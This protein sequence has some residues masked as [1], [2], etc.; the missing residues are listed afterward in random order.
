MP[1]DSLNRRDRLRLVE[2][3]RLTLHDPLEDELADPSYQG[4]GAGLRAVRRQ[5]GLTID[6]VAER[7]RIKKNFIQAIEAG[8]F[9]ALPGSSYAQGFVRSYAEA[10][11]LDSGQVLDAYRRELGAA[12]LDRPL[13]FPI[14]AADKRTPR[15]WILGLGIVAGVCIYLAWAVLQDRQYTASREVPPVPQSILS[16]APPVPEPPV[17]AQPPVLAPPRPAAAETAPSAAPPAPAVAAMSSPAPAA[18]P[19]VAVE[20]STPAPGVPQPPVSV[21]NP[22]MPPPPL[23]QAAANP[24][25]VRVAGVYGADGAD[26]RTVV[27]ATQRAWIRVR[28]SQGQTLFQRT[29][30]PSEVY[31]VPNQGDLVLDAGNLGGIEVTIDG[32]NLPV[33]GASSVARRNISLAPASLLERAGAAN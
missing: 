18:P 33:L 12:K 1:R 23:P 16:V 15:R 25:P 21:A 30:E 3:S 4:V 32:R 22:S 17:I 19:A 8:D 6:D 11:N 27:K 9:A 13:S 29:L 20:P 7:T 10:L 31:R 28:T 24:P 26:V 5:S 14:P 2:P